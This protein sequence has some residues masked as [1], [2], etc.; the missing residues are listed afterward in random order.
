MATVLN[1]ADDSDECDDEDDENDEDE[2]LISSSGK[3][4]FKSTVDA[5]DTCRSRLTG[6]GRMYLFP[7]RVSSRFS[8]SIVV[9]RQVLQFDTG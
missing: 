5:S 3:N 8:G 6:G 1:D 9:D 7:E 4:P 2:L